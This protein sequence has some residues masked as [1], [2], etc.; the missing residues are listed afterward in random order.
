MN[1]ED[2]PRF[3]KDMFNSVCAAYPSSFVPEA[4]KELCDRLIDMY[5]NATGSK[6]NLRNM[7]AEEFGERVAAIYKEREDVL[8]PKEGDQEA[9][10]MIW[11]EKK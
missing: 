6:T 11:D 1:K 4:R 8:R 10:R 3:I 9:Q 5:N 7:L 2:Q